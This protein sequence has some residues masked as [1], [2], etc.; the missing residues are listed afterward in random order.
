MIPAAPYET[1]EPSRFPGAVPV[2]SFARS[3]S[4]GLVTLNANYVHLALSLRYL[5]NAARAAGFEQVW[6]REFTIQTPL[7]K[8][9]ADL[10]ALRPAVLGFSVYIWNREQTF[11]LIELVKKQRPETVIVIGGPEVSFESGPPS[12][13]IDYVVSGEGER[14]WVE[15]LECLARGEQPTAKIQQRWLAY[16]NDLPALNDLPYREEDYAA[17]EHRL[18]YLETSRGCPY[19]CSFCLSALDK[20]VRFFDDNAVKAQIKTLV[21][22]GARRIKFLDR[23]F[24]VRKARVLEL[25][26]WLTRFEGVE[27]H[28]EVVGD[29]LDN[30]V[31]TLLETAPAGMFQFEVGIQSTNEGVLNRI[32]RSQKLEKLFGALKRLRAANRVH[33]HA[34]LIWGLPGESLD[35]IR[36]SFE[37]TLALRPHELQLGFLKFLPGAPIRRLIA[38]EG[39]V[40]QD[41]PPYE[42]ISHRGLSAE[43]L[44]ALKRFEEIFDAYYN[45]GRLRF[46][47]ERLLA[48]LGGW[49]TFE[50]L[51]AY[52]QQHELLLQS[53]SLESRFEHLWRCFR[54][55]PART[56]LPAA[57]VPEAELRDLLRLD[58][59]FHHRAHR[60]PDFLRDPGQD[61]A[62]AP[63]PSRGLDADSRLVTFR[64]RIALVNG[65]AELS[66]SAAPV[67][68]AFTYPRS[69]QGYF[70]RPAMA[71]WV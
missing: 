4:V 45:S 50:R 44:V 68:Y 3:S 48:A 53:H 29:L 70:F 2:A 11:E 62:A 24:N 37:R 10:F 18:A 9:A 31:L 43:T 54:A 51:A 41:R 22:R 14:K 32:Q 61:A 15:L 60:M 21:E 71:E 36:Q 17:L 38:E 33:V 1:E 56:G 28:F 64:H 49:H 25:F 12:P 67:R 52:Y 6:L 35:M 19:S 69:S 27:F 59:F 30:S 7:W 8:M 47:L 34:D 20:Q 55:E 40:F 65:H 42:L 23:T 5:R 58:Y 39:Y 57:A 66:P 63:G 16:G 46:T 13:Y 26:R